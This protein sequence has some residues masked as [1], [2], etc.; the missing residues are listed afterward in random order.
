MFLL[1]YA[2]IMEYLPDSYSR[3]CTNTVYAASQAGKNV[4]DSFNPSV[5]TCW[6]WL[7][8]PDGTLRAA[9][10][11]FP[12]MENTIDAVNNASSCVRPAIWADINTPDLN[13]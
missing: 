6:W 2:E 11:V 10:T 9:T 4:P 1:S 8:S 13:I 5:R 7:R 12:D 3:A